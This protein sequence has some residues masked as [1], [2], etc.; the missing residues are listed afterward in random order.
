M[1]RHSPNVFAL[2]FGATLI[3]LAAVFATPARGWPFGMLRW[4]LPTT[5]ILA[6]VAIMRPLFSSKQSKT[7][8]PGVTASP[9]S[10]ES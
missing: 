8:S 3:V 5:V 2:M 4:L 1:K 10:T 6:A 7:A 9:D